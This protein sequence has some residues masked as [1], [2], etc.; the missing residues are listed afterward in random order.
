MKSFGA[1]LFR[2]PASRP[3]TATEWAVRLR[4]PEVTDKDRA[5]FAAWLAANP[6][7][8]AE[9]ER[10]ESVWQIAADA[11]VHHDMVHELLEEANGETRTSWRYALAASFV[12]VAVAVGFYLSGRGDTTLATKAGQQRTVL[13]EDGSTV[14]LNTDTGISYRFDALARRIVLTRGE[15]F[16]DVK[17]DTARPFVVQVG[18]LE[19]RVVGTQFSV[20]QGPERIEVVVKEGRVEVIPDVAM[21]APETAQRVELAPGNRLE[22]A[23]QTI[24]V[25][26]VDLNRAM[27]WRSGEIEF[28]GET[29]EDVIAE[30]NRYSETP[31]VIRDESLKGLRVSGLFKVS[32][33]QSIRFMLR[34]TLGVEF[35]PEGSR[36]VLTAAKR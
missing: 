4:S 28:R 6:R 12:C 26:A 22:L 13:L 2:L 3:R 5:E 23:R 31:M 17:R 15:A 35:T 11:R 10:S 29:L 32:D 20:R 19:V 14:Q 21:L 30:L 9:F 27:A 7:H 8:R 16:F 18:K 24:K 25:A 33:S 1:T 36:T 34:E